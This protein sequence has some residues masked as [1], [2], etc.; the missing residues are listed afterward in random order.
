VL[1]EEE[2]KN[3]VE[4]QDGIQTVTTTLDL[5]IQDV[6]QRAIAQTL[7]RYGSSH[8]INQA[9]LLLL[10]MDGQI[11]AH[12]GGANFRE[13]EFDNAKSALRQPGSAFKPFV[14]LAALE[15]GLLPT[16]IVDDSPLLLGGRSIENINQVHRGDISLEQSLVVSSNPAAVRL[17]QRNVRQIIEVAHRLGIT[18]PLIAEPTIALGISE[19]RLIELTA[20]YATIANGGN[21]VVP[22]A[23]AAVRDNNGSLIYTRSK[24]PDKRV[25]DPRHATALRSMMAGVINRGTG[26]RADPGYW[27][28]GKTGTTND[29]R[30]AWF[31][32]FSDRHV[33]GVW[34]GN[35]PATPTKG[36]TGGSLPAEIW[37][38]V[39]AAVRS[40][41]S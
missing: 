25:I 26:R 36:I 27:A 5:S 15:R 23:V 13:K 41:K 33:C 34:L 12:I 29:Y 2:T 10:T 3:R 24:S 17:A 39:M 22:Y 30:D 32:G 19:V 8:Q 21:L 31:V 6:A 9:A 20:A 1:A 40:Q 14:Y 35:D 28:A 18:S 4:I 38:T 11:L 7:S 16:S 37:K